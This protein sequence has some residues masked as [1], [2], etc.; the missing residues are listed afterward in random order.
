MGHKAV[1]EFDA[2]K[3]HGMAPDKIIWSR[4]GEAWTVPLDEERRNACR[5]CSRVGLG[6]YEKKISR[7]GIG[8]PCLG[9][10]YAPA[11]LVRRRCRSHGGGIR[12]CRGLGYA[13]GQY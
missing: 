11:A 1:G 5:P 13:Y 3:T 4:D 7:R 6:V 2:G 8:N 12:A 10:A 9:S